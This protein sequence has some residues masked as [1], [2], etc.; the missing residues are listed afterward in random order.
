MDC[1]GI[2]TPGLELLI[3]AAICHL[4]GISM[5]R[6]G[7]MEWWS[8]GAFSTPTLHYSIAPGRLFSTGVSMSGAYLSRRRKITKK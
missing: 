8:I 1:P 5:I 4:R 2:K 7:V 6:N 3:R